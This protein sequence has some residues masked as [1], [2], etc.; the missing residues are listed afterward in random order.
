MKI[1]I[2]GSVQFAKEM[3]ATRAKLEELG[4]VVVLPKNIE[5]YAS[6]EKRVED[7]W[8]KIAGDLF[9]DY[10]DEIKNSDAILAVNLTKSGVENYIGGSALIEMSF[11]HVL[12]K[13]IYLLNP[14]PEISYK[15]E[16]EAMRPIV[17]NGDLSK[18]SLD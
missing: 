5:R 13:K 3:I 11:A 16:I 6:G 8:D 7:K 18:I 15:A 17:L 1:A 4:H 9:K 2:C 12:D 10:W 14:V